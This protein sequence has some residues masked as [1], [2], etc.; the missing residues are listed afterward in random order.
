MDMEY[1]NPRVDFSAF[2][3]AHASFLGKSQ[4]KRVVQMRYDA[5]EVMKSLTYRL[6]RALKVGIAMGFTSV[7]AKLLRIAN[8]YVPVDTGKLIETGKVIN[9][10]PVGAITA[11]SVAETNIGANAYR[12]GIQYGD[13]STRY[14]LYVHEDTEALHGEAYNLVHQDDDDFTPRG[15]D[16]QAKWMDRA[17]EE[18]M[19]MM[20]RD[21]TKAIRDSFRNTLRNSSS[22]GITNSFGNLSRLKDA[23]DNWEAELGW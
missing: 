20:T 5:S 6:P 17:M 19:P 15:K 13:A 11:E 3:D 10:I 2:G 9:D 1:D 22:L 7:S 18:G 14:A 8:K 21:L 16:E 23:S 12:V 4:G